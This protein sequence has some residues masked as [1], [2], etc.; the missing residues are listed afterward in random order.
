MSDNMQQNK[1]NNGDS[2]TFSFVENNEDTEQSANIDNILNEF[3]GIEFVDTQYANYIP[4]QYPLNVFNGGDYTFNYD[5]D[6]K[7][8]QTVDYNINYTIKQLMLICDY[9][10]LSKNL[11]SGKSNKE[12]IIDALTDFE[13]NVDNEEIV[14][15]RKMLWYYIKE[16]K[17]DNFMKKF[18]IWDSK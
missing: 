14:V 18:V 8:S 16:L 4:T 2:I 9:Y 3:N 13:Y 10:G 7:V 6:V 15:K 11:K 1:L 5:F 12:Q 17:S